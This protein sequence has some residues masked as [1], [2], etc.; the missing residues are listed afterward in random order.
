M[1]WKDELQKKD[2]YK[3]LRDAVDTALNI[4]PPETNKKKKLIKDLSDNA[5]VIESYK[6]ALFEHESSKEGMKIMEESLEMMERALSKLRK[7]NR[8]LDFRLKKSGE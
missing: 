3:E 7:A 1:S 5:R 2:K 8:L 4:Q 6:D